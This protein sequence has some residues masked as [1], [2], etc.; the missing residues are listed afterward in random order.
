M[1]GTTNI[2][3]I[4]DYEKNLS[5]GIDNEEITFLSKNG[6]SDFALASFSGYMS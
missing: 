4:E 2:E 6:S 5:V 3:K 1:T